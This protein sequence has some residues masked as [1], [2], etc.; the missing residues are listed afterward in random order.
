[1]LESTQVEELIT[2]VSAMDRKTLVRQIQL[3]RAAFPL[4]FTDAFL[5]N[6]EMDRL[7]HIFLALCIHHQS[8]PELAAPTAA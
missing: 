2:V 6:T 1:M 7:R 5:T 4:D 8:V 3:Y